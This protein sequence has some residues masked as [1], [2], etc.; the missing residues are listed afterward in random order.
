MKQRDLDLTFFVVASV[1]V[2]FEQ[3]TGVARQ[4]EIIEVIGTAACL[5]MNM[6]Y[7][8]REIENTFGRM[9]IL[10]AIRRTLGNDRIAHVHGYCGRTR[11]SVRV[12]VASTSASMS[13]SSS[14]RSSGVNVGRWASSTC[15][16][17]Y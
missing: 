14:V 5:R 2:R 12:T 4:R 8:K 16:R 1:E 11:V 15:M 6:L 10:A 3:V 17:S 13:A 7:L 9:T